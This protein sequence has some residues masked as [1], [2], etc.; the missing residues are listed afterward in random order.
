MPRQSRAAH[1]GIVV[2]QTLQEFQQGLGFLMC[3]FSA[4]LLCVRKSD[5]LFDLYRAS[6]AAVVSTLPRLSLAVL[7]VLL[8]NCLAPRL[9]GLERARKNIVAI[10]IPMLP[11][12]QEGAK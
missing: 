1:I 6:R 7:A 4:R 10:A 12:V 8:S 9:Y 2:L 11:H 5:A 3:L